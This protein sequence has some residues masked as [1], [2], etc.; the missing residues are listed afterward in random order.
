MYNFLRYIIQL[1]FTL[2]KTHDKPTKLFHTISKLHVMHAVNA[3]PSKRVYRS[4]TQTLLHTFA[5]PGKNYTT[6]PFDIQF[7]PPLFHPSKS[8]FP[9]GSPRRIR[10]IPRPRALRNSD[11]IAPAA[12]AP[13]GA[14][15]RGSKC[16]LDGGVLE[17]FPGAA[18]NPAVHAR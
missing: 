1:Y 15:S 11:A 2:L 18:I 13:R 5:L 12:V 17:N 4:S 10:V 14:R 6:H 9:T 7:V 16:R 3:I 8:R